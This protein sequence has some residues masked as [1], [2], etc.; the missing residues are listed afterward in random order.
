[1][2]K[3]ETRTPL[4]LS[5]LRQMGLRTELGHLVRDAQDLLRAWW[6]HPTKIL[7]LWAVATVRVFR[8]HTD[9]NRFRKFSFLLMTAL[10]ATLLVGQSGFGWALNKLI[11][12]SIV[13]TWLI[14]FGVILGFEV[15]RIKI[16][17]WE[18]DIGYTDDE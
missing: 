9:N 16:A 13:G 4:T 10:V 5:T 14:A 11:L 6:H 7:G 8:W 17:G 1:M 12:A 18:I 2:I 3:I 15:E